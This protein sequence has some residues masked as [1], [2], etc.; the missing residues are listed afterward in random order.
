[1]GGR[2]GVVVDQRRTVT[3]VAVG[4]AAAQRKHR[5]PA[6]RAKVTD[7]PSGQHDGRKG[8]VQ[9][10]DGHE[11]RGG[12]APHPA[13]FERPRADAVRR[14]QHQRRHGGLD[15][16][17]DACHH[18][19]IAK[20]QVHP[21]QADQDEQRGQHKQRPGHNAAPGAVHEP[22]DVGG[23]LLRLG[24]GQQHAVVE[25]VQKALF[26]DPAA[27]LHQLGMHDRDLARGPAKADETEL[28]PEQE[29][30]A[31]TNGR[32]AFQGGGGGWRCGRSHG[33][34]L[35]SGAWE[36]G[37]GG[38]E[39]GTAYKASNTCAAA[40]ARASSLACTSRRPAS[41]ASSPAASGTG[42]PPASR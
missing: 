39:G 4:V 34:A 23:Q 17:E 1:M 36:E 7:E 33:A 22:A 8:S 15:A 30:L 18:R 10:K 38:S 12:D 3:L 29:G 24:A 26:A 41:T 28:E 20:P 35:G 21:R 32:R 27:A 42:M 37:N 9:R 25:G 5:G 13:V 2:G 14:V 11:R 6:L 19:Y 31:K 40:W 16:V